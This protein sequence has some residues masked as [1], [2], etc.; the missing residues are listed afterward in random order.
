MNNNGTSLNSATVSQLTLP[1]TPT[2]LSS[3]EIGSTCFTVNWRPVFGATSYRLDAS[4]GILFPNFITNYN[5]RVVNTTGQKITN[6]TLGTPYYVR[7]RAVNQAGTGDYSNTF[8]QTPM[9][10]NGELITSQNRTTYSPFSSITKVI[11]GDN[12]KYFVGGSFNTL[13]GFPSTLVARLLENGS[14]DPS[15]FQ[16]ELTGT[17][18]TMLY[19]PEHTGLYVAGNIRTISSVNARSGIIRLSVGRPGVTDGTIDLS[20]DPNPEWITGGSTFPLVPRILSTA[21]SIDNK[22]VIGG[23]FRLKFLGAPGDNRGNIAKLNI[24]G[25]VDTGFEFLALNSNQVYAIA[26]QTDGKILFN[27]GTYIVRINNNGS[28]DFSFGPQTVGNFLGAQRWAVNA[29]NVYTILPREE[30][31]RNVIYLGGEFLSVENTTKRYL[32]KLNTS[33]RLFKDFNFGGTPPNEIVGFGPINDIISYDNSSIIV[34]GNFTQALSNEDIF[35]RY[36][37]PANRICRIFPNH[38]NDDVFGFDLSRQKID[39]NFNPCFNNIGPN[40]TLFSVAKVQ[41]GILIGGFFTS[42]NNQ[43]YTGICILK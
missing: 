10:A 43:P 20:F 3:T 31:G 2:N 26:T 41:S 42:Y 13:G 39:T 28:R 16:N 27:S 17:V 5:N 25:S 14:R 33:G 37:V 6:L 35:N 11:S 40:N 7:V 32:A 18:E 29:P 12:N 38:V 23:D 36:L 34:I 8:S 9:L 1:S 15:F 19:Y 4:T 21:K 22:I 30:N 24:D